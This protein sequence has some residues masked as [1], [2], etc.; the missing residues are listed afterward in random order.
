MISATARKKIENVITRYPE[1]E[2][3]SALLP[4]LH[5]VQNDNQGHLTE[6]MMKEVADLL[7]ITPLQ[8]YE[9]ATFY[10]MYN[11]KPIGKYHIQVCR[12]LPCALMGAEKLVAYLEEK[13]GIGLGETTSD[14]L[15][16]L[17]EVECLASC[18]TAPMMQINQNYY[19]NLNKSKVDQILE[20]LKQKATS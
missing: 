16:T 4:A 19:E 12:T 2:K 3:R 17:T 18:G 9:V 10:T 5:I 7:E 13:L 14:R 15:F 1:E 11:L 20:E 6:E 8:V